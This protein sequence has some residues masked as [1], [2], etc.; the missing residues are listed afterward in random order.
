MFGDL[1]SR[2]AATGTLGDDLADAELHG[3]SL[4]NPAPTA[5]GSN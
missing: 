5:Q 3:R 4:I 1:E 2:T